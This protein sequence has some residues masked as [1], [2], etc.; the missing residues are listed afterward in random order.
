MS[1][2]YHYES[3]SVAL[4]K[5]RNEGYTYD[6]NTNFNEIYLHP[7][8]YIVNQIYQYEGESNPDDSAI[9][10]AIISKFGLKGVFVT[11]TAANSIDENAEFISKLIIKDSNNSHL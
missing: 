11:G 2:I 7:D 1:N 6:F 5:L 4:N 8:D 3:V 9:V 10:Y